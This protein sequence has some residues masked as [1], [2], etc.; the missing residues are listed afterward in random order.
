MANKEMD[1]YNHKELNSA[2]NLN[3]LI[4]KL[5]PSWVLSLANISISALW[6]A[7]Q[8]TQPCNAWT[9]EQQNCE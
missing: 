8:A 5:L 2:K 3:E 7:G 1:I 6:Y 4:S 9:T